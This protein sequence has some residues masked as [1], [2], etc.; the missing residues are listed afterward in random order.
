M[1]TSTPGAWSPGASSVAAVEDCLARIAA[2]DGDVHAMM[3]VL[4]ESALEVAA[5][6]D[7]QREQGGALGVLHGMP[8][9]VKD[10]IDTAGVRT[11][12]GSLHLAQHVPTEDA[13]VMRRLH[14]AGA[15][16]IGKASMA[17]FAMG[18]GTA[19]NPH[20][21]EVRNPWDLERI[22]GGSSSGSAAGVAAQMAVGAL[23]TDTGGSVRIPAAFCGVVGIRPTR[24]RVPNRGTV[25]V[26]P[27]LDTVG[28]LAHHAQDVARLLAAIDGYDREDPTS[29]RGPGDDVM[30]ELTLGVEGLRIGVPRDAF[31]RGLHPG[32]EQALTDA[33]AVLESLGARIREVPVEGVDEMPRMTQFIRNPDASVVHE[34]RLAR[35]PELFGPYVADRLR[36]G[37]AMTAVD[38]ARARVWQAWWIRQFEN[39]FEDVDLMV[40]PMVGQPPPRADDPDLNAFMAALTGPANAWV[41]AG[42]PSA[43]VPCGLVEDLP[44]AMQLVGPAWRDGRVLRAAHAFQQ[45]TD[46]HRRRPALLTGGTAGV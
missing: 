23:G 41:L 22:P 35:A 5:A 1:M 17:E 15:V 34:E 2:H 24:G 20:Y 37:L 3:T 36:S 39:L 27:S 28:A 32:V 19:Q 44:V 14:A 12:A 45:A 13:E 10:N 29:A 25:P 21:P 4:G 6:R 46:W 9:I 40:T 11:T 30:A 8:V 43:S 26:S 33:L 42:V 18:A 38:S 16:L 7:R 31:F